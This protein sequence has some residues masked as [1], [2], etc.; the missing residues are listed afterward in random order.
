MDLARAI[1]SQQGMDLAFAQVKIHIIVRENA[2]KFL[3][4]AF[5]IQDDSEY[6][7]P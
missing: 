3:G 1:F 5:G 6:C 2:G 7:L 4:D